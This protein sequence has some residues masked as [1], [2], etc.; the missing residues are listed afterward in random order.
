[1]TRGFVSR[2]YARSVERVQER[3]RPDGFDG[4]HEVLG[5]RG[6]DQRPV[7][8]ATRRGSRK[9][10]RR[11]GKH[12][13]IGQLDGAAPWPN[14]HRSVTP[15]GGLTTTKQSIRMTA[16]RCSC[17]PSGEAGERKSRSGILIPATANVRPPA[18]LGRGGPGRPHRAQPRGRRPRAVRARRRLRGR[19]PRRGLPD[20]PGAG[21]ARRSRPSGPAARP[22]STSRAPTRW[23][24]VSTARSRWS[25]A[26][27][28]GIGLA[29]AQRVRAR[30][31]PG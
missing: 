31:G 2:K 13:T 9:H 12:P 14:R 24:S 19:D 25:P 3:V 22:A 6:H 17:Q 18:G 27:S 5:N 1:M 26:S 15:P 10:P 7:A 21:R 20:P 28:R 23:T 30:A 4:R 11:V 16:D 8:V 29:I